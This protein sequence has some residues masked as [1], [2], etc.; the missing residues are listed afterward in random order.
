M[1]KIKSN[2]FIINILYNFYPIGEK[3]DSQKSVS[4]TVQFSAQMGDKGYGLFG[5]NSGEK[6]EL[7]GPI[8]VPV[9]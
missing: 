2:P 7:V 1:V 3:L 9:G 4:Q 8:R 5:G 6:P